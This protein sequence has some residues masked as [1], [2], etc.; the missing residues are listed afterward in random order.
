MKL[1][2]ITKKQQE[3]LKLIYSY[4]FLQ[5]SQI[6][7]FLGHTD[8]RRISAWLKD[9]RDKDYIDWIYDATDYIEKTKPASYYLNRA[10][11]SYL[12]TVRNADGEPYYPPDELHKRYR[13]NTRQPDFTAR[14]LLLADCSLELRWAATASNGNIE[15][16]VFTYADY[17]QPAHAYHFLADELKPQLCVAKWTT[18]PDNSGALILTRSFFMEIFDASLP[19]YQVRKRLKD[20]LTFLEDGEWNV[21]ELGP[22]PSVYLV[23]AKLSDLIYA[24]RRIRRVSSDMW[25]T[26]NLK[27]QCTTVESLKAHGIADAKWEVVRVATLND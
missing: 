4:R 21:E 23:F 13:D 7:Q 3:I 5:R 16:G 15:Y 12:R 17:T 22:V 19:Q 24:K 10:G 2:A 9:L 27:F 18:D 25:N 20:Y 1:P 14:C 11:I 26:E 6:Q 8:K